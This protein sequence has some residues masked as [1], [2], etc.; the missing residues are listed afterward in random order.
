MCISTIRSLIYNMLVFSR[1]RLKAVLLIVSLSWI[2]QLVF[3]FS[4]LWPFIALKTEKGWQ[5]GFRGGRGSHHLSVNVNETLSEALESAQFGTFKLVRERQIS[6]AWLGAAKSTSGKAKLAAHCCLHPKSGSPA[7][8]S[9]V[10]HGSRC[11]NSK[12]ST[13][14]F[15][16]FF[17]SEIK[18]RNP[19]LFDKLKAGMFLKL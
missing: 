1:W 13:W 17:F 16:G 11:T 12:R 10:L 4:W 8:I 18:Q 5:H 19:E 14:F 15:C 9:C 7:S 6:M 2:S 3:D